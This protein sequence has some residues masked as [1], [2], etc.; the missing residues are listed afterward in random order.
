MTDAD[1]LQIVADKDAYTPQELAVQHGISAKTVRRILRGE[2]WSDVTGVPRVVVDPVRVRPYPDNILSAL[3]GTAY[4]RAVRDFFGFDPVGHLGWAIYDCWDGLGHLATDGTVAW[5]CPIL[6]AYVARIGGEELPTVGARRIMSLSIGDL[7]E[8]AE[9]GIDNKYIAL[10]K[11]HN[12]EIRE[13]IGADE[14]VYLTKART[15]AGADHFSEV[16]AAVAIT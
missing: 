5:R 12:L 10:A 15:R 16:C 14:F 1:A 13:A 6:S 11:R 8:N 3:S 9:I 4:S 2:T 7:L